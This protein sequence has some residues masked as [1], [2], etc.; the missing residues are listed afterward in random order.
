MYN[1]CSKVF[2][3]CMVIM[4]TLFYFIIILAFIIPK[5]LSIINLLFVF[6]DTQFWRLLRKSVIKVQ[7]QKNQGDLILTKLV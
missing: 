1:D 6:R 4:A 7:R 2:I 5:F 3:F